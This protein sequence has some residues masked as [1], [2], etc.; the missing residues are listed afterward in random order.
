M[1]AKEIAAIVERMG[2]ERE[3]FGAWWTDA[4]PDGDFQIRVHLRS[5]KLRV[6]L[7]NEAG[8]DQVDVHVIDADEF[9][10]EE[11]SEVIHEFLEKA[12]AIQAERAEIE[13]AEIEER[14]DR[15]AAAVI[16][17]DEQLKVRAA[18]VSV[19]RVPGGVEFVALDRAPG[20]AEGDCV[21]LPWHRV[22]ALVRR[23]PA[24]RAL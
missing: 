12:E 19:E 5:A 3:G 11:L 1:R 21:I 2:L 6:V 14:R 23:P 9:T 15:E 4:V 7:W 16:H 8:E 18:W 24:T 17:F 20:W 22:R 10:E 13:A